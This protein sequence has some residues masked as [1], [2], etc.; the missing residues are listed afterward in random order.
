MGGGAPRGRDP[1]WSG[2]PACL[3]PPAGGALHTC[4][5]THTH[6]H[7]IFSCMD[8]APAGAKASRS[9][10]WVNWGVSLMGPIK[11]RAS[12]SDFWSCFPEL[13]DQTPKSLT[14]SGRCREKLRPEEQAG[15]G[16]RS[17][18]RG[19]LRCLLS[20]LP[21]GYPQLCTGPQ[22]GLPGWGSHSG[23]PVTLQAW[24]WQPLLCLPHTLAGK[25]RGLR[26]GEQG[27]RSRAGA[28]QASHP[29]DGGLRYSQARTRSP[30]AP[31]NLTQLPEKNVLL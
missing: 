12:C 15:R 28:G 18:G 7:V 10:Q 25:G 24:Q 8:A 1:F 4:A 13:Q 21:Y 27:I 16:S 3:E 17:A 23:W 20:V 29:E 5:N 22:Q 26:Q 2:C 6:A 30:D 11:P 19:V 14:S 31:H 9:P